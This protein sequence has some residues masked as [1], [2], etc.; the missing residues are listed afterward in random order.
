MINDIFLQEF[1]KYIRH[2]AVS[3][4]GQENSHNY[5][6]GE[7]TFKKSLDALD[8]IMHYSIDTSAC[9]TLH[10]LNESSIG[11]LVEEL[12][13]RGI[14]KFHINEINC[15]GNARKNNQLML[16]SVHPSERFAGILSQLHNCLEINECDITTDT[17]C[18]ISSNSIYLGCD[19]ALHAC[20]ELA[21][22]A[23]EQKIGYIF[24]DDIYKK[25]C[26]FFKKIHSQ[27]PQQCRY[28]SFTAPGIN[29][30]LNLQD[31]CPIIQEVM[32]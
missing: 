7:G 16:S 9:I 32:R 22:V 4:D 24:E 12:T 5:I 2:I 29:I 25:V 8:L 1:G 31:T 28:H 21:L 30:C 27:L 19:G 23:P 26:T 18:T 17:S 11:K 13:N 10:A 14:R 20:A 6:R 3:I 15:E